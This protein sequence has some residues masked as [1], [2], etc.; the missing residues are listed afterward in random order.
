MS[1]DG[2]SISITED[3][4]KVEVTEDV[5][6]IN[7]T[8]S[9]TTVEAKGISIANASAATAVTYQ[10]L[11]NTLGTGG[12]VAASLDHINTNGFN[13]NAD[14]TIDGNTTIAY[15]H[16]LNFT[17]GAAVKNAMNLG[18]N[19]ITGVNHIAFADA[20]AG[21]GLRWQNI[22]IVETDDALTANSPGDLQV[23]YKQADNSYARRFTVRDTGI[24]VVG[25]ITFDGGTTSGD[26]NFGDDDKALFGPG[27]ELKIYHSANN[28]SYIHEVGSGDLNILATNL[29]LQDADENT[30]V[31]VNPTGV[32][33]TGDLVVDT[34]TLYVDST[35][36]RVGIGANNPSNQL[37][38][39]STSGG[40]RSG[41]KWDNG[42]ESVK[43]YFNDGD[44]N[45]DFFI[46]YTGT[47]GPEVRFQHDGD[48]ILNSGS[49]G[50]VG[51]GT[52]NP[53]T[54]LDVAGTVTATAFSGPLTGNVTGQVSDISNHDT[55]DLTEGTNKYYTDARVNDKLASGV[56]N[57]VTTGYLRGPSTFTIDPA[58]H[59]DNT[60]KVVIA[61]DLQVDGT[62]TTINSTELTIDDKVIEVA[63]NATDTNEADGAG[64]SV[65]G[66]FATL[67][68][69]A[70][71]DGW[72]FNKSVDIKGNLLLSAGFFD[73]NNNNGTAGQ[74]LLSTGTAT[75]WGDISTTLNVQADSGD[76][77]SIA[78]LTENLDIAGGTGISTATTDNTVTVTLDDTAVTAATYG[79]SQ[80]IPQITVDGQGRITG[81]TNITGQTGPTGATGPLPAGSVKMNFTTTSSIH[82]IQDGEIAVSEPKYTNLRSIRIAKEDAPGTDITDFV[83]DV[84]TSSSFPSKGYVTITKIS[85]P[86]KYLVMEMLADSQDVDSIH[87]FEDTGNYIVVPVDY[88]AGITGINPETNQG[89]DSFGFGDESEVAVSF[90]RAADEAPTVHG[91][92][93]LYHSTTDI[94]T[95]NFG[96]PFST[97]KGHLHWDST[98]LTTN[99]L[100]LRITH[101]DYN[102]VDQE[103]FIRHITSSTASSKGFVT[104]IN[105]F[106]R[107]KSVTFKIT[108]T[109]YD[110][111]DTHNTIISLEHIMG[112]TTVNDLKDPIHTSKVEFDVL[113]ERGAD[114]GDIDAHL[115]TSSANANEV[116]SWTGSAYDWV[117][118]SGGIGLTDISV[119]ATEGTA[120]GDGGIAYD[121]TTGVFTYNPPALLELGT[122][123]GTALE[124]DTALLELGTTAGTALE[125]DTALLE[126]GTTA[127]TALA[128]DTKIEELYTEVDTGVNGVEAGKA[129]RISG[130]DA[131]DSR[132]VVTAALATSGLPV[133][134]FATETVAGGGT[135][136]LLVKGVLSNIDTSIQTM[137][138][139]ATQG[140]LFPSSTTAGTL[141]RVPDD[142]NSI[143]SVAS[144]VV[145][146]SN[147]SSGGVI[148]VDVSG[149]QHFK[150]L[151]EDKVLVGNASSEPVATDLDTLVPKIVPVFRK[152]IVGAVSGA[153]LKT[154]AN[155]RIIIS[156]SGN[157]TIFQ[158][159]AADVGKTWTFYNTSSG[160]IV[161][162]F[163]TQ[164]IE[165]L[166]G[167]S[168]TPKQTDWAIL[169]GGIVELICINNIT[170][171][172]SSSLPNF[173]IYGTGLVDI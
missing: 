141:T 114:H 6:T 4:T 112:S 143:Q 89:D 160:T 80:T 64:L 169:A 37:T 9:V 148:M 131:N 54:T 127:T 130:W 107:T 73:R 23:T 173:L 162:D 86:S 41:I 38:V 67:K 137:G 145:M 49:D 60:G 135:T 133:I 115:T 91:L 93:Y 97:T 50:K 16:T 110:T 58:G 99:N 8:P 7:I 57:I 168:S 92:K 59:G 123:A 72:T 116:L 95:S 140:N 109:T 10:G 126:L 39:R 111:S 105:R 35:N 153:T 158:P 29:K 119:S 81:V 63:S 170:N 33:V 53:G 22:E 36:N 28:Q 78:M 40:D 84:T 25:T 171:G 69:T 76:T 157:Y 161:L 120:S 47:N 70:L 138:G 139:A 98:D 102:H 26:L 56:D 48:I 19:D 20:G 113:F 85:D 122:T 172:G 2:I 121:N 83:R 88:V 51:I 15:D 1:S 152:S 79:G 100:K 96:S 94:T 136:K 159:A 27:N 21:E 74:A 124:G 125:G 43:A 18:N 117:A 77:Q 24:D 3:V 55:D 167:A 87:S 34:N 30:K 71:F 82:A 108:D 129:Y 164:Y 14:N 65:G 154:Y 118:Q 44:A 13:K 66:T 104:L 134:G 142:D 32:N 151:A 5:T 42:T 75:E 149:Q 61:G 101:L 106:N 12:N 146:S 155:Q 128:G 90:V 150:S 45:S 17:S 46:T 144:V 166:T 11:S 31:L 165:A 62:T 147:G 156:A 132:P 103:D 52:S 68:Y 163:D